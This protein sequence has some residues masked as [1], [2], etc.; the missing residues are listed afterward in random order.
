MSKF[1]AEMSMGEILAINPEAR[2]VLEGF[3]MHCCGC[4]MSQAEPLGEACEVHGVDVDLVL[5]ELEKL[6]AEESVTCDCEDDC[7]CTEDDDCGCGCW[8]DDCEDD[9]DCDD[10]DCDC[11]ELEDK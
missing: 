3:G 8:E 5:G 1:N 6:D 2:V 7:D 10:D 11:E 4:P 9:C